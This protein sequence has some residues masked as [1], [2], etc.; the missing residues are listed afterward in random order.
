ML[1]LLAWSDTKE[2][3]K[4]VRLKC[5]LSGRVLG[6]VVLPK[7]ATVEAKLVFMQ[8]QVARLMVHPTK[9]PNF[10]RLFVGAE[11][12]T[13]TFFLF[14]Q[15]FEDQ[16]PEA[17]AEHQELVAK[18]LEPQ[19]VDVDAM[20][21]EDDSWAKKRLDV[22][23]YTHELRKCE[24]GAEVLHIRCKSGTKFALA[25]EMKIFDCPQL[26]NLCLEASWFKEVHLGDI[27]VFKR[28]KGLLLR[29]D[30]YWCSSLAASSLEY[31]GVPYLTPQ[32]QHAIKDH[33]TLEHLVLRDLHSIPPTIGQLTYLKH[34]KLTVLSL[35][36]DVPKLCSLVNL[37]SLHMSMH[38]FTDTMPS[39]IGLLTNL[40]TLKILPNLQGS[41]PKEFAN[42]EKLENLN[43]SLNP[44]FD[45]SE[46]TFETMP[47]LTEINA[48]YT[49]ARFPLGPGW[50]EDDKVWSRLIC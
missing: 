4:Y 48:R 39:E 1:A 29:Y 23:G 38:R 28:L 42:L 20:W 22:L 5:K 44:D 45:D 25:P 3:R 2:V 40:K 43:L 27:S 18:L 7:D 47:K 26:S 16:K 6:K 13:T 31:L 15:S 49:R 33:K 41:L 12:L 36:G 17:C 11:E 19:S 24:L 8:E 34:L 9:S 21:E 32:I 30:C 35:R 14:Y 37:E 46:F 10:V 50:T